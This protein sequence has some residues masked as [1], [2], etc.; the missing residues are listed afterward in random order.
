MNP[1]D[2]RQGSILVPAID[3]GNPSATIAWLA[4]AVEYISGRLH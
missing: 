4:Q 2:R 3:S 1:V